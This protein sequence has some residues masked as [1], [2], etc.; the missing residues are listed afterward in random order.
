MTSRQ[1]AF[2]TAKTSLAGVTA[3]S[4]LAFGQDLKILAPSLLAFLLATLFP[5]LPALPQPAHL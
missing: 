4:R 5:A 3:L 1:Q 2:S